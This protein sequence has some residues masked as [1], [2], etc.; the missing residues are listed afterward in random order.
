MQ[1]H[2]TVLQLISRLDGGG[3]GRIAIELSSTVCEAGGRA[4]IAYDGEAATYELT[5][6]GITPVEDK[7]TSRNPVSTYNVV[8]RLVGVIAQHKVDIVHAQN[9]S[10]A[11]IGQAAAKKAGCRL[12]T[13]FHDGPG[14]VATLKK[15]SRAA[16][17][18]SDHIVTLSYLTAN[19]IAKAMPELR[20]RISVVP[21][22]VDLSRFDPARV[23][24][25]R[26]IQLANLWRMPDDKPII[27]LP[28]RFVPQKGH[29][30]LIEALA[31]MKDVDLR[32]I[33]VGPS[34][35]GG[36]YREQL[37]NKIRAHGLDDRIQLADECRDM[38]AALMLADLVVAP[39]VEPSTYNRV[40][41][42]AQALGRPLIASDF[43][44]AREMVDGSS[45]AWLT[46]P[47]DKGALAWAIRDAL[48]LPLE[49]RQMRTEQVIANLRQRS[50]RDVMC[51]HMLALYA[52][53]A[54]GALPGRPD[55]AD[56][57]PGDPAGHDSGSNGALGGEP[58]LHPVG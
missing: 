54:S 1:G 58:I 8:R 44:C 29:G 14:H 15:K 55:Q 18:A 38:P 11:V 9:A 6:H 4:L 25:Q 24:A 39:Y 23:T 21:Y 40:I 26:V 47:K 10:L 53:L 3:S 5:R 19:E 31:E 35:D 42:E 2:P 36:A 30:Q 17:A 22:G 46:P 51:Q 52:A 48:S 50:D 27:M 20:D 41:V 49:E 37:E 13:T 43:P 28:G 34:P 12:V 57:L 32:C 45:M 7:L 33:M 16:F 56:H